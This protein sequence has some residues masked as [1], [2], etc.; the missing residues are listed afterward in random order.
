LWLIITRFTSY[1]PKMLYSLAAAARLTGLSESELRRAL[2]GGQLAGSKDLFCEWTI[3][4]TELKA[5]HARMQP[6]TELVPSH[7]P[8]LTAREAGIVEIT[9]EDERPR[10][11]PADEG[12]IDLRSL[13]AG[14]EASFQTAAQDREL[15]RLSQFST[16]FQ[17]SHPSRRLGWLYS[18]LA[19]L[20]T[21]ALALAL[22]IGWLGGFVSYHAIGHT[23][24]GSSKRVA[25]KSGTQSLDHS[26]PRSR[27]QLGAAAPAMTTGS[28]S[29]PPSLRMKRME[30]VA[31]LPT[32]TPNAATPAPNQEIPQRNGYSRSLPAPETR[33][34]TIKGWT[35]QDIVD[36]GAVLQGRG[37]VRRVV[38]GDVVPEL[39]RIESIVKWGSR[40]IVATS[41]GL[42]STP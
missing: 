25:E 8:A 38:R 27:P 6:G 30:R 14:L 42:I 36:G 21:A 37:G 34:A 28:I 29:N 40:W 33:P 19:S 22:A 9:E 4:E 13:F 41:S 1:R 35:I 3:A 31:R 10:P 24:F 12:P 16:E 20:S 39:G 26:S 7:S 2:E 18:R 15:N 11:G 5:L 32:T 17:P 23:L